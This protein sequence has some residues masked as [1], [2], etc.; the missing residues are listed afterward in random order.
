MSAPEPTAVT[1]PRRDPHVA[2][3]PW[4]LPR[5]AYRYSANLEPAGGPRH[6]EAGV[7]GESEFAVDDRYDSELSLRE[8]ILAAEPDRCQ[9]LPHLEP[10]AWDAMQYAFASLAVSSP[11]QFSLTHDPQTGLWRFDNRILGIEC[12]YRYGDAT[13][14]PAGPMRT[15]GQHVQEDVV[16]LD[17]REGHLWADGGVVTFAS[18]WSY[19]FDT[20][21][22]FQ[23]IHG[24]VPRVHAERIMERAEQFVMRLQPGAPYRRTNWTL[25]VTGHLDASLESAPVWTADRARVAQGRVDE[26]GRGLSLRTEVQHLI[27][28]PRSQA[29]LFLIRTY[30]LTLEEVALV[31]EWA[32]RL[33]NVLVELP[34]D[35]VEYKGLSLTRRAAIRWLERHGGVPA[36]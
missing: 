29:I 32:L 13:T 7:W 35:L 26:V 9:V 19:G 24:P 16:L 8:R 11:D 12:T 23:K 6:T 30:T 25:G 14:L 2:N 4:P 31:P 28:L 20:G 5:D 1:P 21:M 33:R 36:R 10:A 18:G 17:Q 15:L 3:F 34:D 22:A 27:R